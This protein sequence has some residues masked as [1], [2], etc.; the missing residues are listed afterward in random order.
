M[1]NIIRTAFMSLL[2]AASTTLSA[3][4]TLGY[5]GDNIATTGLSNSN[6]DATISCAMVLPPSLLSEYDFC[7]ITEMHVGLSE[8]EGL[9]SFKVWVR[10]HLADETDVT[11]YDVPLDDLQKGW[12]HIALPT[13][14]STTG[15][16]SLFFGYSYTQDSKVK[17]ISYNGSKKTEN[18]FFISSG[19]KW[20]DYTKS[21]GPVS[22]RAGLSA[23]YDNGLRLSDLRLDRRSQLFVSPGFSYQPITISG[24]IQNIGKNALQTFSLS[25]SDNGAAADQFA[26][27]CNGQG[28]P[29][30]QSEAFSFQIEPGQ[31]VS[32]PACDLPISISVKDPNGD[33][34]AL[35]LACDRTLYYELGQASVMPDMGSY[36]I[37]E[38]TSEEC[39]YAPIGQ[40]RLREAVEEAHKL[41]LGSQY[42]GWVDGN[43]DGYYRDYIILSRHEGYGPAD[44]WRISNGSDYQPAVFGEKELTFAPAMAIN[45]SHIPVSSTLDVDSLARIIASYQ[46][47]NVV[48]L[49]TSK[50]DLTYDAATRKLSADINI[51]LWSTTFCDDPCIV[52]CVK[53]DDA[54]SVSQKNYYPDRYAS[55][56]QP[57]VIR[58]FLS[59][60]SGSSSLYQG[61]DLEAIMSGQVPVSSITDVDANGNVSLKKSF[62]GILPADITSLDGL[63]LVGYVYDR[64]DAGRIYGAFRRDLSN[65]Q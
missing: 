7:D 35:L 25:A 5:C 58:C 36:I 8:V 42:Q 40:T 32:A 62:S 39:G 44:P 45:R 38:Y 60:T 47:P 34:S 23:L 22:I 59:C 16:D 56:R 9:T 14:L 49:M 4:I 41:N 31:N 30:G 29:F 24:T 15:Q 65:L 63:T 43:L 46:A 20:T 19:A 18:S 55:D 37:E 52:L 57:D 10:H 27:Q 26:F 6:I 11:S 3:Q 53:Q 12:N 48:S 1:N 51:L 64:K 17:C 13:A 33:A 61:A 21:Y 50:D 54:P 28:V 2:L